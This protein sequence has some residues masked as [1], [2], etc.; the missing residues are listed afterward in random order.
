MQSYANQ[1]YQRDP[2]LIYSTCAPFGEMAACRAAGCDWARLESACVEPG[3]RHC[4]SLVLSLL[5]FVSSDHTFHCGLSFKVV[6]TVPFVAVASQ[7]TGYR[8]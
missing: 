3:A 6:K 4:L 2:F 5:S 7:S 1:R 8:Y